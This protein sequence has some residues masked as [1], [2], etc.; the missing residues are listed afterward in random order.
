[1]SAVTSA[2]RVTIIG[3]V[4]ADVLMHPVVDLPDPGGTM[5][6]DEAAVRV[7]GAGA[8][9][10]LAAAELGMQV[11]LIGALGDDRI[12]AL[13][14]DELT[15]AGLVDDLIIVPGD[16]TGLTVALQSPLRDRTFLTF[17]GVNERWQAQTIPAHALDSDNLLLCDYFVMPRLRGE[18]TGQLFAQARA[19]GARTFFDTTW[20]PG[21]FSEQ[22]RA[23][24]HALLPH[25]DVFLPNELEAAALTGQSDDVQRA[26]RE[27]QAISRSWV[28]VKRG[29]DGCLAVGPDGA[30]IAIAAPRV[31]VADTTGAGDAFNAGLIDGLGRGLDWH[32]AL[33]QATQLASK[34]IARPSTARQTVELSEV[35]L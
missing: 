4:Q 29:P 17:L 23:E 32:R 5:L 12:G 27:L 31:K 25:V 6:C 28:V 7:G 19:H 3:C 34:I 9:A 16:S 21:G 13:M 2:P 20:D 14:V 26:A 22:S 30:E 1:M 24:V 35:R 11:K 8:N 33:T 18:A 15:S 10:G